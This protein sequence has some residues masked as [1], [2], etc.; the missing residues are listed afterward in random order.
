[1]GRTRCPSYESRFCFWT[2]TNGIDACKGEAVLFL[3]PRNPLP[4]CPRAPLPEFLFQSRWRDI[5]VGNRF[6]FEALIP[7]HYRFAT[8]VGLPFR[9]EVVG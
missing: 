5:F 1:M 3:V 4:P 2:R 9:I 7:D 8:F 6:F